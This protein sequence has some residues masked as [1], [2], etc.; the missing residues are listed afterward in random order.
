MRGAVK[1]AHKLHT[2]QP[3]V[4]QSPAISSGVF[5]CDASVGDKL[6]VESVR[7]VTEPQP[8]ATAS[9]VSAK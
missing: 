6:T 8:T 5:C 3:S 4:K 1:T 7:V 2:V 9:G